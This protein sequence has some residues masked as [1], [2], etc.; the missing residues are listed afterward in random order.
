MA[1]T[2]TVGTAEEWDAW[3]QRCRELEKQCMALVGVDTGDGTR[4]RYGET[5]L[6]KTIWALTGIWMDYLP[7]LLARLQNSLEDVRED[8]LL[9]WSGVPREDLRPALSVLFQLPPSD[10]EHGTW[11]AHLRE[12]ESREE[13]LT[14][15]RALC[16]KE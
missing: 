11:D 5:P 12:G 2:L 9:F 6:Q 4:R 3:D 10:A 1:T 7:E 15:F 16:V 13:A 14:R 8:L